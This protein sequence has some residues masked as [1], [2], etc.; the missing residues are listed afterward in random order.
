MR[1][2]KVFTNWLPP[3]LWMALIYLFSTSTFSEDRTSSL[4][5]PILR[6]LFPQAPF[7]RLY[8]IHFFIRKISHFTEFAILGLLWVRALKGGWKGKPY[9]FFLIALLISIIY[10]ILDEFH[11]SFVSVRSPSYVDILIDSAGA[12][13]SLLIL[14]I[15]N[16]VK[17]R[18]RV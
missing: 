10:A 12:A 4:I 15:L 6:T 18:K 7:E 8:R 13:S 2:K 14:K 11:Q 3:F 9:P 1:L 17:Y 16:M 5:I